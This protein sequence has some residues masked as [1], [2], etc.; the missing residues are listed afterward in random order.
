MPRSTAFGQDLQLLVR[1]EQV[2]LDAGHHLGDPEVG[3]RGEGLLAEAEEVE[4]GGVAEVEELEVVLPDLEDEVLEPVTP[5]AG[6]D[7]AHADAVGDDAQVLHLGQGREH[8][9]DRADR[10]LDLAE[11]VLVE[12]VPVGEVVPARSMNCGTWGSIF[13]GDAD[14]GEVG[15]AVQHAEVDAVGR[16]DPVVPAVH[17]RQRGDRQLHER[18]DPRGHRLA[19]VHRVPEPELASRTPGG[20]RRRSRNRDRAPP[21]LDALRPLDL[22]GLGN[23]LLL[24]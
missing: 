19:P 11:P 12:R 10:R 13:S 5:S 9:V 23:R 7:R 17:L 6:G 15:V 16:R 14:R 4:V 8:G 2:D 24:I 3:D 22:T 21:P 18:R 20:P 1:S